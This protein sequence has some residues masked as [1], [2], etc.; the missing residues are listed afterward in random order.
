M[1]LNLQKKLAADVLKCSKKRIGLDTNRLD[2]IKEA[3]T[4]ADIRSLISEGAIKKKPIRSTSKVRARKTA[5]Q[6]RK[7]RR[8]GFGRKKGKKTARLSKKKI[9]INRIRTQRMFLKE[10]KNKNIITSMIYQQLYMKSKGGFFRSKRHIKLYIEE[11]KL[12]KK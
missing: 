12:A 11:H 1:K 9:W 5:L 7:G 3:I 2:D 10:L 8:K 4:K 6:K